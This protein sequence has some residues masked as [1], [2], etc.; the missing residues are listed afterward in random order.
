MTKDARG[1][2]EWQ[3]LASAPK[4]KLVLLYHPPDEPDGRGR[5]IN[6]E[7]INVGYAPPTYPRKAT[8]WCPIPAPPATSEPRTPAGADTTHTEEG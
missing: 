8:H 1:P 3:P 7:W 5:A 2:M 6:G 4:G